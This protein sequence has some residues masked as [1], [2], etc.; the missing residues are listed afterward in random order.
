MDEEE[1]K[2]VYQIKELDKLREV[3]KFKFPMKDTSVYSVA[4]SEDD[5]YLAISTDKGEVLIYSMKTKKHILTIPENPL[6][7][8]LG[9]LKWRKQSKN[10]FTKNVIT[11]AT[12]GGKIESYHINTKK[13]ILSIQENFLGDAQINCLDYSGDNYSLAVSGANPT[14]RVYDMETQKLK[15]LLKAEEG[16]ILGHSNR[17]FT[18]KFLQDPNIILSAGWDQRILFWDLRTEKPFDSIYGCKIYGD[19]LDVKD[20]L[21]LTCNHRN[22]A[23]IQLYDL[24][25][26]KPIIS[27]DG[28][29]FPW[30]TDTFV[31]AKNQTFLNF[32]KFDKIT[33]KYIL[34][35]GTPGEE[36]GKDGC[37]AKIFDITG[38]HYVTF[39]NFSSGVLCGDISNNNDHVVL[40][41]N[42]GEVRMYEINL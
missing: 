22:K 21:L 42:D 29:D 17:V 11:F 40:G 35:G 24:N 39:T 33:G 2:E 31:T 28:S 32:G 6:K 9:C 14:V 1:I 27:Q 13:R 18:V 16:L 26:R 7:H 23:Q 25:S 38:K 5:K 12:S 15:N 41:T 10:F 20:G 3:L 34:T 30:M 19:A 37:E 4:F 36:G 8:S